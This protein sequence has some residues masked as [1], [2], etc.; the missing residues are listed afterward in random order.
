MG[1]HDREYYRETTR[2]VGW[3]T[4]DS[5]ATKA[6]LILNV[7]IFV[8]GK[9]LDD[10][11]VLEDAFAAYGDKILRGGQVWR[12]I[13]AA[14]LHDP[15]N[16]FHLVFNML[17]LW[18]VGR[19]MESFYGTKE[20]WWL[21]L[22]AAAVS[23]LAWAGYD[24]ASTGGRGSGTAMVG[25]SGAVMAVVSLYTFYNPTREV[26]LFIF[27]VQM[28][29]LLTFYVVQDALQLLGGPGRSNVAFTAHLGGFGYALAFKA[30]DLR[31]GRL[32]AFLPRKGPR[33][34]IVSADP[35]PRERRPAPSP[36]RERDRDRDRDR[37]RDG[38]PGGKP[39]TW[40]PEAASGVARPASTS[41]AVVT[42]DQLDDRLDEVLAKIATEGPA[43]L[44]DD[45][46]RI[47]EAA[48]QRARNRRGG[49]V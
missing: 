41:G 17:F 43:S 5:P 9:F 32:K 36:P 45:E 44:T 37:K 33:L 8:L 13:T 20:F 3:L 38:R 26:I 27:P 6:I 14:F 29:L 18:F 2:G 15:G 23:T 48:S 24:V 21:Y 12:L 47:L 25:A 22:S 10:P 19:E 40:T 30:F 4:G 28:W 11:G 35:E 42:E 49:R 39:T 16:V 1:I 31:L 7:G 46:K 34:R